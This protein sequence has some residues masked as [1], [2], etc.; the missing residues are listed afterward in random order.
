LATR[1]PRICPSL[2]ALGTIGALLSLAPSAFAD[3]SPE[4]I[5]AARSLGT[6]GVKLAESGDC[7]GAIPKLQG[8]EKLFHAP[9]TADWLGECQIK[10]G[11][12]VAGTE[13]LNRVVHE[14]L[15]PNAPAAFTAAQQRANVALQAALPKI[16][17]LKIHVDGAPPDQ[18]TVTVDDD[19]V[20]SVLFDSNRP[21]DPGT[22][23]VKASAPGFTDAVQSVQLT[24]GGSTAVTLALTA[25]GAPPPVAP[26]PAAT[27]APAPAPSEPPP[28]SAESQGHSKAVPI[29]LLAVGGAGLVVGA[30]FGVLALGTKSSLDSS[31]ANKVCPSSSQ[32]NINSLGTQ[33]WVSNIGFGVGIIAGALGTY[34]LLSSGGSEQPKSAS[35]AL[36]V[37]PWVGL[38]S[39]GLGGTFQ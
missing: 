11:Q 38:G 27:P 22:H 31:C 5:A 17:Q 8:A 10:V 35:T 23:Q 19:K 36:E 25:T 9:T 1:R 16:A 28:T 15:A 18:V 30:S 20:P 21:T 29:I 24:P 13:T 3:P 4:D 2:G 32:G 33:A 12:L 37:R 26:V 34:F 39:A 6:D 7:K 14:T